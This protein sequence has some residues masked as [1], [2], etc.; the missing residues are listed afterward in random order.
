MRKTLKD[1]HEAECSLNPA[2]ILQRS[3]TDAE[4]EDAAMDESEE[5]PAQ[6]SNQQVTSLAARPE[7]S[8]SDTCS[9]HPSQRED[10]SSGIAAD[11]TLEDQAL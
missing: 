3:A 4:Q 5:E 9:D 1:K 2:N 11:V 8:D 6:E 7:D 10:A